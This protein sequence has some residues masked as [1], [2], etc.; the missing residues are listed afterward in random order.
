MCLLEL[1][2]HDLS[3]ISMLICALSTNFTL[4]EENENS[5]TLLALITPLGF[6]RISVKVIVSTHKKWWINCDE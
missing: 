5:A 1:G 3:I 4:D 2:N 6:L